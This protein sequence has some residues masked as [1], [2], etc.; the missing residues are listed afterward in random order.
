MISCSP[1]ICLMYRVQGSANTGAD[2]PSSNRKY[3]PA[4]QADIMTCS[5]PYKT[6]L[7]TYSKETGVKSS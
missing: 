6:S 2:A 7:F 1:G 3:L 5:Q 4:K